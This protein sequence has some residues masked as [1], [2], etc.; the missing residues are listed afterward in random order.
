MAVED[1]IQ[2]ALNYAHACGWDHRL[3]DE[4]AV[5]ALRNIRPDW[6]ET[7]ALSAIDWVR[8][9]SSGGIAGSSDPADNN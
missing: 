8:S 2:R 6:S 7:Q 4:V 5:R 3:Q 1:V 9:L